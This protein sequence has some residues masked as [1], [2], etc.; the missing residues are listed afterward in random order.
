MVILVW[1]SAV[2]SFF[3]KFT[4]VVNCLLIAKF[5]NE[6]SRA[7]FSR[8]LMKFRGMI[9]EVNICRINFFLFLSSFHALWSAVNLRN[10]P[11]RILQR[12][13]VSTFFRK[14]F[15]PENLNKITLPNEL[16]IKYD[17]QFLKIFLVRNAPEG[18]QF[19]Y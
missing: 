13:Q 19:W 7:T 16:Q 3:Q 18:L 17:K 15:P 6:L 10:H 11:N 2:L 14:D 9:S 4:D 5:S 1:T 12:Y 8:K